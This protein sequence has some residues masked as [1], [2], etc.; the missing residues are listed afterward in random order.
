[1]PPFSA[2]PGTYMDRFHDPV[3]TLDPV[4]CPVQ[5]VDQHRHPPVSEDVAVRLFILQYQF[6]QLPVF[7]FFPRDLPAFPFVVG[8]PGYP[9]FPAHPRNAPLLRFVKVF[10]RPVFGSVPDPAQTHFLS[11][12]LTFFNSSTV[13]FSSSS[14][15]FRRRFSRRKRYISFNS[16]SVLRLPRLSFKPSSPL[17]SYFF[18]QSYT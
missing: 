9:Q 16:S 5:A 18:T 4:I 2:Y 14:N 1:M 3:N 8:C 13:R 17:S 6:C 15:R 7:G 11:S 12:S 10:K